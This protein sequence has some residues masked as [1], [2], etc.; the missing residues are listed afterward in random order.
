MTYPRLRLRRLR[1]GETWRRA[2][3]ETSLSADDLIYPLFV[4][5]GEGVRNPVASM[6]G[7]CQLSVDL[8]VK[9]AREV[10]T[11]GIPAVILFGVPDEGEKDA[12]GSAAYDPDGLVPTAIRAIKEVV[13]DL[14]VWAECV[15]V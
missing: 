13:P 6:P 8:I 5:G 10:H 14:L 9:E 11:L 12:E 4:V 1:R 2:V 7:V 3:R 15:P